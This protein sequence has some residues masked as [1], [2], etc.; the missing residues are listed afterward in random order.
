MDEYTLTTIVLVS[1]VLSNALGWWV[2]ASLE[3]DK[4]R[5]R[6]AIARELRLQQEDRVRL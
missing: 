2:G 1:L 6:A 4:W 5:R 3:R